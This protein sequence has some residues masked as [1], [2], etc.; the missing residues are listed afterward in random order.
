MVVVKNLNT[1]KIYQ[2]N[3]NI[4]GENMNMEVMK[5]IGQKVGVAAEENGAE[6][7]SVY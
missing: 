4:I 1:K 5:E 2:K 7:V 6:K 3:A